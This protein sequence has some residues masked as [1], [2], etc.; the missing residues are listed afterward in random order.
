MDVRAL[1]PSDA[2]RIFAGLAVQPFVAGILAFAAFPLL[3]L[4]RDGQTLAGGYPSDVRASA[5]SLA[6]GAALLAIVVTLAGVWPAAVWVMKRRNLTLKETLGFGL[7][8]GILPYVLL[9]L[10]AGGT[11]GVAGLLRGV[12]LSS[13]L[14]LAG[15]AVFWAIAIR[16]R[17]PIG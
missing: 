15:A 3:L 5:V 11:Y 10:A 16:P 13:L 6:L 8:F 14:G 7:A 1:S 2:K 4:D 17:A 9:A 12:A